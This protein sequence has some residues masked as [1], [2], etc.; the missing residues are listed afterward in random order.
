MITQNSYESHF[1]CCKT[2]DVFI[3]KNIQRNIF[4]KN[5]MHKKGIRI[6]CQQNFYFVY[7]NK[8]VRNRSLIRKNY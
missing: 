1:W 2:I 4:Y 6:G 7:K 5:K 8:D 3:Y